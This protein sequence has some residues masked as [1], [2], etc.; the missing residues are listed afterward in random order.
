MRA[1]EDSSLDELPVEPLAVLRHRRSAKW[2]RYPADVVPL[3]IAEMDYG[4]APAIASAL[5]EAV[6][7]S[8]TGYATASGG[9]GDALAGFARRRWGWEIDPGSVTGVTDIG[10]GV[11]QLLRV[12]TKPGD[13]VVFNTPV[14]PPFF[15][16]IAEAGA[17]AQPVPLI[18]DDAGWRLDLAALEEAFA[19]HPAVYLLCNPHNPVGRVHTREELEGVVRLARSAGVT[20][21]SDEIHGPLVFPGARFQPLLAIPGAGE[22][23]ITLFSASKAWNLAGL[24]C[25]VVVTAGPEAAAVVDRFPPDTRWRTGHF[26]V[27]AAIAAFEGAEAWLDRLVATLERRRNELGALIDEQLP[28]VQWQPPEATFLAWLDCRALG[29]G[30]LPRDRFLETGRVALEPGPHFGPEGSGFV[31]LNFATSPDI[32]RDAIARMA[33]SF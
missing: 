1:T 9:L 13:S 29:S 2:R 3:T 26:G 15:D 19:T 12:L 18:R 16:W 20:V 31:R 6:E 25:A 10:T 32:L 28:A 5:H 21:I 8:D 33:R 14:Y 22:V 17:N 27:I 23:G 11:V 7:T 30:H 4:L 24:K